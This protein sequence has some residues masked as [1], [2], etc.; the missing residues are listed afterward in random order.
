MRFV[1]SSNATVHRLWKANDIKPHLTRTFKRSN[2][3][4]FEPKFW[5]VIGLYLNPPDMRAMGWAHRG[6]PAWFY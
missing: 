4:D 2:D 3:K 5:D 1:R 6:T